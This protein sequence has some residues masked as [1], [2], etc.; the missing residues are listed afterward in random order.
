MYGVNTL[1]SIAGVIL[2]GLLLMP[3]LGLKW[4]LIAGAGVDIALGVL[5]LRPR[6]LGGDTG[7]RAR[8]GLFAA[9]VAFVLFNGMLVHFDRWKLSSGV[10][11]HGLLPGPGT[12]TFP[13]YKDGRTATVSVRRSRDDGYLTL[14]T[15]GKPDAS[16]GPFWED[17]TM[18]PGA[19]R[20]LMEDQSTQVLLPLIGL[21]HVPDAREI[22]VIGQ[23]SG[24]TSSLLLGS[25]EVKQV[26]TVEIEPQMVNASRAFEPANHRVFDDPRSRIVIDDAKA[27]FA[28]TGRKFDL[29]ISEPS[30]PWVSGVSG[31]F[32]TEFYARV[33]HSLTPNG[34][35]GQWLHL[36]EISDSLVSSV[37]AAI[38][39]NFS[40][41]QV[42]FTSNSDILILASNRA[43][44][45]VPDWKVLAYPGIAHDLRRAVPMTP[46]AL[47]AM[48]L[49]GRSFL[50]P[51]LVTYAQVNSDYYPVLDL[52]AERTRFL[53][54]QAVGLESL[55][56]QRFDVVAALSGRR[57]GFATEPLAAAPE[58]SRVDALALQARLRRVLAMTPA[59]RAGVPLD[60]ALA[61]A[62]Y[63]TE[64]FETVMAAG[65]P[66]ADWHLWVD[67]FREVETLLHDGSSGVADETFYG[68]VHRYL[69]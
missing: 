27:Y 67:S 9:T 14:A 2:A 38:D 55:G 31:L 47:N 6:V 50:H 66:P 24:M 41:Y 4:L 23:G 61:D 49:A 40:R 46:E 57:Q 34:V 10:F 33:R 19:L 8:F 58:I 22:A 5:I 42:Y 7:S 51:Y 62:L 44:P 28:A 11:R 36:Y 37:L 3:V 60:S 69:A 64:R 16:I 35:L 32:T 13:F 17:S 18:D 20:P 26:V 54:Q 68:R 29:I 52:G 12:Y 45:L 1:G 65:V 59:Q 21:A 25:P 53:H 63:R 15:N 39:R 43:A 48:R 56:D 30:N